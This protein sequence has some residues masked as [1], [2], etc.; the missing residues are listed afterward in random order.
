[1]DPSYVNVMETSELAYLLVVYALHGALAVVQAALACFLILSGAR[2]I[3]RQ[4]DS[5]WWGGLRLVLGLMLVAPVAVGAPDAL[6]FAAAALSVVVLAA[7]A[8][9]APIAT[10]RP[11]RMVRRTAVASAMLTVLFMVWEREDNL[12]LGGDLLLNTIEFRDEELS[13]QQAN[14]PRSPKVG[15]VAPDFELQDPTGEVQVRLS[16]FRGKR[17]V[18]LVFGSYT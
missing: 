6:S 14:D 17:P 9:R 12:V 7:S 4:R 11:K 1:V 10:T 16:D 2:Q 5:R 8:R 15:D 13:W 3:V 18:A